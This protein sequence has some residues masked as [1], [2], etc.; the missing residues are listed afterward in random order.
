MP[1]SLPIFISFLPTKDAKDSSPV[2]TMKA[3]P[4][5]LPKQMC[6]ALGLNLTAVMVGCQT[7]TSG[8]SDEPR[9]LVLRDGDGQ[10]GCLCSAERSEVLSEVGAERREVPTEV[11]AKRNA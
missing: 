11:G 2:L 8:V 5:L 1:P 9:E 3:D 4:S 7:A 6:S 10:R